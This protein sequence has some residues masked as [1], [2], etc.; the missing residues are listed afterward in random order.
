MSPFKLVGVDTINGK[1]EALLFLDTATYAF[2]RKCAKS[3]S[4]FWFE[5][6]CQSLQPYNNKS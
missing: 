4:M 2:K 5:N 1:L 3:S 6:I